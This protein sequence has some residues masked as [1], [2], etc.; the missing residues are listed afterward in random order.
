[1][2]Q[3]TNRLGIRQVGGFVGGLLI[4]AAHAHFVPEVAGILTRGMG[5]VLLLACTLGAARTGRDTPPGLTWACASAAAVHA[6]VA[7]LSPNSSSAWVMVPAAA[8]VWVTILAVVRSGAATQILEGAYWAL[9]LS[10]V[11]CLVLPVLGVEAAIQGERLRGVYWNANSAGFF[12]A[13]IIVVTA[14]FPVGTWKRTVLLCTP[15]VAVLLLCESRSAM[16]AVVVGFVWFGS[17]QLFRGY[18]KPFVGLVGTG[19]LT[20]AVLYVSGL[21][22]FENAFRSVSGR[23]DGYEFALNDSGWTFFTG[24]GYEQSGIEIANTPLRWLAEAGLLACAIVIIAYVVILIKGIRASAA[25]AALLAFGIVSSL[26]E[27]WYVASGSG[28]FIYF[29]LV[30]A[31][32]F[33]RERDRVRRGGSDAPADAG[34]RRSRGSRRELRRHLSPS[35]E[36]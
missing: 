21:Y 1:M 6:L 30:V 5:V 33:A 14:L 7:V 27:G 16:L 4:L 13:L 20:V 32:A 29:W 24:M 3:I 36:S 31:I 8:L 23:T 11:A 12:A 18:W 17:A 9:V 2:I 19:V 10:I 22:R 15:A 34:V 35:R 26:F 25:M 28:L